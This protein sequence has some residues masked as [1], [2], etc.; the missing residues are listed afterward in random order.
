MCKDGDQ[1]TESGNQQGGNNSGSN[2]GLPEADPNLS[3]Y[4][5]R[6]ENP[7]RILKKLCSLICP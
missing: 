3:D 5:R 1:S 4:Y 7:G 2:G 6:D